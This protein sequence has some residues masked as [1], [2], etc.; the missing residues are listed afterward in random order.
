MASANARYRAAALLL[1][2]TC[3]AFFLI[4]GVFFNKVA[5]EY[6]LNGLSTSLVFGVFAAMYSMSS[7]MMGAFMGRAGPGRTILVGGSLMASGML[8]SSVADSYPML[9]LT[10][11]VVGGLGSGAMWMPTSY[12]VFD[13]FEE[14]SIKALTG[15]VSSGSA[16][17]LLVYASLETYIITS[18]GLRGAFLSVGAIVLTLTVFAF[19]ASRGSS[20]KGGL[21]VRRA[22]RSLDVRFAS[23]YAYYAVGNA[24]ARTLVTIFVVPLLASRG[25]G[26]LGGALAVTMIGVGSLIGR[27]TSGTRRASEESVAAGGFMLQGASAVALFFAGDYFSVAVLATLFGIGYG[28]YIPEFALIIRKYYGLALY[29]ALFGVLLTS[30]GI[31][32]FVGPVFE[33]AVVS[34]TGS[35]AVGFGLSAAASISVGAL[36]LLT[37]KRRTSA[38]APS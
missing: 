30:F 22:L 23:F 4:Y 26:P 21:G 37:R 33:G 9:V 38:P 8:L 34:S 27:F 15:L 25:L 2:N 16:I 28:T 31:G 29:P 19:V 35:Y 13:T 20:V 17:G 6:H 11:G 1:F 24:F 12:V 14:G 36:M 32:A 10:Y 5:S 18:F 7:L 3:L